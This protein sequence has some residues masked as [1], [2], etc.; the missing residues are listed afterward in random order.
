MPRGRP[1]SNPTSYH[2][3]TRQ[4]YVTRAG[5][6]IYLEADHIEALEKYHRMNLGLAEPL[7]DGLWRT[8]PRPD[9]DMAATM[10]GTFG[11]AVRQRARH[12]ADRRRHRLELERGRR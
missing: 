2:K 5:K 10:L 6:K 1:T 9:L 8:F 4:Y 11:I 3:H 12:A 7:G